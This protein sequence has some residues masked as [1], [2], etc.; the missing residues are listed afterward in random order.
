MRVLFLSCNTGEGHNS[1]AK[2][3]ISVL[4]ARGVECRI[5]DVLACLSPKFSKF[6]SNWHARLYKYAPKLSD[7]GYRI[8]ERNP[9]DPEDSVTPVY[10]LLSLGARK[11]WEILVEGDY[12]AVVCVHL[13][14]AL[15]MT[16]VRKNFVSKEPCF[17]AATDY[18]PAPLLEYSN[19]D[20]YFIPRAVPEAEFVQA[21]IPADRLIPTGIPVRQEFYA[22]GDRDAARKALDLPEQ[23]NVTLLMC[24]S[25]GCGPIR[26]LGKDL[27]RALPEDSTVV[28]ICGRND[29]LAESMADLHDPKMRVLGY[30]QNVSDYMDAA[31][32]I[33]TKPGGLSSTEAACKH[34]PM[35]FINAVGGCEEK[36]FELFLERGYAVGSADP[37]E[38]AELAVSLA[39]DPERLHDM[40]SRLADGFSANS[41][42]EI[43]D[44]VMSS[45]RHYAEARAAFEKRI[46]SRSF[47]HPLEEG[48]CEMQFMQSQTR[49]NLA[50]SF[51]GES[52]A[53]TRYTIYA[54]QARAEGMEWIARI[55]EETA[56]NEAVHAEEFLEQLQKMDGCSGNIELDAG[57]PYQLGSTADN[58]RFAAAGELDEC[59]N[60]YPAFAE[61]ARREGFENAARL[62]M[63]IARVE[64]VHH[65]TF[66]SLSQQL[67]AGELTRKTE[68]VVWRCVN[69]GYTYEAN[70]ALERCPVCG[71]GA[72]WQEGQ[73]D[74]KKTLAKK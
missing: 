45:A 7:A 29:K 32:L 30:T 42:V 11:L 18:S 49:T 62:W 31:D 4:E 25:M 65:N 26:K 61:M 63:Q 8:F 22:H 51:A 60:A 74:Q 24:G 58:L 38:T 35:V 36:N 52:Q 5:E 13:F 15:M 41:A 64:G 6:I 34:L 46:A 73:V 17:F 56:A 37:E 69:C 40:S 57:Y 48:G 10:E 55:F 3:I 71:K 1:T 68:P 43:A 70:N 66:Q 14:S 59:R 12:D 33:V 44:H 28:A 23:G 19:L 54:Q 67:A 16:E 9:G 2:A 20:G 53:R 72:G 27:T 50:R 47:G 21:G 39:G